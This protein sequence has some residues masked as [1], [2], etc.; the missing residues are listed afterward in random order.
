[1]YCKNCG[2]NLNPGDS[3]CTS[4]GTPVGQ[5]SNY[6]ENCGTSVPDGSAV[7]TS[8]GQYLS[9][10][11]VGN[12][13]SYGGGYSGNPVTVN[14]K[15]K[16]AGGLLGIFLGAF[17]VHNFY[18]GYTG[19]AI[20]QLCLTLLGII[21]SCIGIGALLIFA[22]EIWGLIEGILILCGSINTDGKGYPLKD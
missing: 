16:I 21:L 22:I 3:V 5:G 10:N 8:C 7:C 15:S 1:M 17:G 9:G 20:L 13:A 4:C 6:C 11:V 12:V 19:K 14:Q 2:N 18:L